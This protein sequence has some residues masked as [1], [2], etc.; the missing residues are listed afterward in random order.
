MGADGLLAERLEIRGAVSVRI[1]LVTGSRA[2]RGALEM[3]E[4]ALSKE[5]ETYIVDVSTAPAISAGHAADLAAGAVCRGADVAI[6]D[7]VDLAIVHGDRFEILG[8]A[9]GLNIRGAPIAHLG[10]GDLTEGSQDDSFRHA[11]TKLSHLHFATCEESA[12]RIIQMGEDP[13]RVHV[14]GDPGI[15][16]VMATQ[17]LDQNATFAAV[18]LKSCER[19][20]LVCLHPNTLGSVG[21]ELKPL[22]DALMVVADQRR[23]VGLVFIGPN[24]DAGSDMIRKQWNSIVSEMPQRAVYHENLPGQVYL[25][26][27]RWC[28]AMVG[29]SSAGLIEAPCFGTATLNIGDRQ[30]GRPLARS[31]MNVK[32]DACKIERGISALLTFAGFGKHLMVKN[33]YGDGHAAERIAKIIGE[34]KDPKALLRK[35]FHNVGSH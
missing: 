6:G 18:G 1:A 5:H 7:V 11:I 32:S 20:L 23:D 9:F 35:R 13:A 27:M 25:S 4:A 3:V 16:R 21:V 15:D 8:A 28:D 14:T 10:G 12:S 2:D 19:A 34:I 29:N 30:Q 31:V 17:L 22:H 24:A 33:P 26:L